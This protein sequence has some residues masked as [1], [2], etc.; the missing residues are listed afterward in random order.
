M[1]SGSMTNMIH[2]EYLVSQHRYK[3]TGYI[4]WAKK[5]S[6]T[7]LWSKLAKVQPQQSST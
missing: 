4:M 5:P 1:E 6:R 3:P 7:T 2:D